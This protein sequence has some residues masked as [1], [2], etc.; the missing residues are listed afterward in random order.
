MI[1]KQLTKYLKNYKIECVLAPLFKMLEASFE[2]TVP[3]VVAALIDKGINSG[4]TGEIYKN[5]IIM[6]LLGF[7]GLISSC[8]AQYFAAKA[9]T[10]FSKELRE[11]LFAHLFS[12]S[13]TE[14]DNIGT[15]T[16]IT[17]M[18]SD[19]N[20]AQT[21]VNMFLRLFLRS[22][23]VVL[24]AMVMAFTIDVKTALIFVYVIVVLSVVVFLI[25]RVN[26]PALKKVQ[27]LLDIVLLHT[28]EN[29]AGARVL[30]A[31]SREE[32][33]SE[34]FFDANKNLVAM[35]I[36]SG[37]ISSALNPLTY[38]IVNVGI[39]CLVYSGAI[40]VEAGILTQGMV[41]ALYNYM[42]Q[43]LVE[44]I[45][46]AN[47]IVTLNKS[48]A[49]ASRLSDVFMISC[50][51]EDGNIEVSREL[52]DK[53]DVAVEFND[54]F[55]KYNEN[56]DAALENISFRV[57]KGET[58]GIIGGTGS[59][60]TSLISLI[61]RFYDATAGS[62]KV[63]GVDAKDINIESLRDRIGVVL[64]KAVLFK[65]TVISN[66]TYGCDVEDVI[67]ANK[68]AEMAVASDVVN[69]KGGMTGEIAQAGKNLSGGQRQR[70]TI[71]RALAK[72][73]DI[74]IL[75][76]SASALDFA[77]EKKLNENIKALDGKVTTFIV[78]QRASSI[79]H[80]DKII[81]LEDGKMAGIGTHLELVKSCPV[82][83]EI[84]ST[85][86]ELDDSDF[87]NNVDGQEAQYEK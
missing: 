67:C 80:A 19:V 84:Y 76:D 48:L 65:G 5:F 46:L 86:F 85:Q 3:L 33:E 81:V 13:F 6:I 78:T 18:T 20:Q 79:L 52:I 73:P 74:L 21:G 47:L 82:Y 36:G 53:A 31:F 34:A 58:V 27:G 54:V 42:S 51:Q 45:K 22:P 37:R 50:S 30:R 57:N 23:F 28:R 10:G 55:L 39:V 7:I 66:I 59:G 26:V 43:I 64:Q 32:A 75:D 1:M 60:K 2:L 61:P 29:L 35:Q 77:T 40:R 83:R 56:G 87:S 8:T 24:G 15:S 63:F 44:L 4:N 11:D 71:A 16:M 62:V 9:A 49:S 41:I 17:R 72:K 70:L 68:S 38:V 69:A 12:M 25:M 14:I